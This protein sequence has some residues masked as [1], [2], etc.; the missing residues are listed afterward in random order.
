MN[1]RILFIGQDYRFAN[2]G[3]TVVT[4]RNLRL[5]EQCGCMVDKILVPAP[6]AVTKFK[7]FI[8][9]QSYGLDSKIAKQIDKAIK[10]EYRF[11]FFDRSIF[12]T[13]IKR[14]KESGHKTICFFHNVETNL[15]KERLRVTH[16]I[17]YYLMYM[18]MKRNESLAL[19]YS[20]I[21]LSISSRDR[22]ILKEEVKNKDVYL[23]PTSFEPLPQSEHIEHGAKLEPYSLFVGSDFFANQEGLSWY[24]E[25]VAPNVSMKLKVVGN[26]CNSFRDKNLPS[27]VELIGRVDDLSYFYNNASCVIS[28]I[29]S[30]SGLKTKT[31]EALRYGKTIFGTNEAFVGIPQEWHSKIGALCN[32]K[33]EFIRVIR[34]YEENPIMHNYNSLNLF[35]DMFSDEVALKTLKSIIHERLH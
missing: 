29:L 7:N 23:L 4:K 22:E 11:I 2:E 24:I 35:D 12:G 10:L 1:N 21:I 25:N 16:S 19:N 6:S 32:T 13:D 31:I 15:S 33:E 27:N 17:S 20:D 14:F 18:L 5:L 3:V 9:G 34:A 28:P 30:G 8:F 26:I